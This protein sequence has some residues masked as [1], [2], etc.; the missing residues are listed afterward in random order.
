MNRKIKSLI[1]LRGLKVREIAARIPC[2]PSNVSAVINGHWSSKL[3]SDALSREL[4]I[5]LDKVASLLKLRKA[6]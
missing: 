2:D 6:A 5:P 3:V 1:A 4:E